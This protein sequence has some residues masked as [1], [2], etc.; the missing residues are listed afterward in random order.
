M[1]FRFLSG[2]K[3]AGLHKKDQVLKFKGIADYFANSCYNLITQ[4]MVT[5]VCKR[6]AEGYEISGL[7][8]TNYLLRSELGN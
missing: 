6:S 1:Y 5:V 4:S 3:V 2:S 8:F 7:Q